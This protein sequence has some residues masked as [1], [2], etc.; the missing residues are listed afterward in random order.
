MIL[1][2][3]F[4][5]PSPHR[6]L[7]PPRRVQTL[8]LR[9]MRPVSCEADRSIALECKRSHQFRLGG[10][11]ADLGSIRRPKPLERGVGIFHQEC[12]DAERNGKE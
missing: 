5:S 12:N 4:G 2:A 7:Y 9:L 6:R 10:Q 8:L 11:I 3:G 1:H